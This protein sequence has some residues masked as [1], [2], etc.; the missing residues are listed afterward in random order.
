MDRPPTRMLQTGSSWGALEYA[1]A[2]ADGDPLPDLTGTPFPAEESAECRQWRTLLAEGRLPAA[3]PATPPPSY[4]SGAAWE[5]RLRAAPRTWLTDYHLG[6]LVHARGDLDAARDS[7]VRSLDLAPSAWAR[8]GLAMLDAGLVDRAAEQMLAAHA[9]APDV[10][11]LTIETLAALGAAGRHA[12]GL[13]L[14]ETLPDVQRQLGRI[15]LLEASAAIGTGD[16]DR[17]GRILREGIEIADL[18]EGDDTLTSLWEQAGGGR[19]TVTARS[20]ERSPCMDR[21]VASCGLPVRRLGGQRGFGHGRVCVPQRAL[22]GIRASI[23]PPATLVF[24]AMMSPAQRYQIAGTRR[25]AEPVLSR[26]VGVASCCRAGA[27]WMSAG[28]VTRPDQV[29]LPATRPVAEPVVEDNPPLPGDRGAEVEVV[30]GHGDDLRHQLR[31]HRTEPDRLP[32]HPG[33]A[34][35]GVGMGAGRRDA[36]VLATSA[37]S[38]RA[39][40]I[41]NAEPCLQR[42]DEFDVEVH[43]LGVEVSALEE[44]ENHVGF[45]LGQCPVVVTGF[46]ESAGEVAHEGLGRRHL[47]NRQAGAADRRGAGAVRTELDLTLTLGFLSALLRTFRIELDHLRPEPPGD[48]LPGQIRCVRKNE[49]LSRACQLR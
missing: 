38:R 14:V 32:R 36:D 29:A 30:V 34:T 47:G 49:L 37:G 7:Y 42:C 26:V 4:V 39:E 8:R 45:D 5:R 43:A 24:G 13:A 35:E 6:A 46:V 21:G 25:T 16:L 28:S 17:A 19:W 18:R 11:Q 23:P 44:V 20:L 1:R 12:D 22:D 27:P 48:L 15:Q 3:D 9:L 41:G 40:L 2:A 33:C 10:W 31:G